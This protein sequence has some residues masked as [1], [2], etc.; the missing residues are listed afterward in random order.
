MHLTYHDSDTH[1]GTASTAK[2]EET[3]APE[4]EITPEMVSSGVAFLQDAAVG[5]DSPWAVEPDFVAELF[6]VMTAA[7]V[8]ISRRTDVLK[9]HS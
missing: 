1:T 7:R 9:A 3:G 4:V 2:A 5:I 8:P 6:R